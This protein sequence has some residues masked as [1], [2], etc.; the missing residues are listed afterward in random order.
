MA[1]LESLRFPYCCA[2]G[3][4][5]KQIME[6][7]RRL[8]YKPVYLSMLSASRPM[9]GIFCVS[10]LR[11]GEFRE[12]I[13]SLLQS[14]WASRISSKFLSRPLVLLEIPRLP[15]SEKPA[16]KEFAQATP[17]RSTKLSR[18]RYHSMKGSAHAC[19]PF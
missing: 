17:C 3:P 8:E 1:T 4:T 18:P 5:C 10:A 13:K 9:S 14:L 12:F 7:V 19:S 15:L 11:L 16:A 2:A 6:A